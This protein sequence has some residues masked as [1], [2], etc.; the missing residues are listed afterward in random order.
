[1]NRNYVPSLDIQHKPTMYS[2]VS[3]HSSP[4]SSLFYKPIRANPSNVN[5]IPSLFHEDNQTKKM[6]EQFQNHTKQQSRTILYTS[7]SGNL[8]YR[9]CPQC[10]Q[11]GQIIDNQSWLTCPAHHSFFA[12]PWCGDTRISNIKENVRYCGQNHPYSF[13]KIHTRQPVPG[14]INPIQMVCSCSLN[15]KTP[16]NMLLDPTA[17]RSTD[18]SSPFL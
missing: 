3:E 4:S 10:G 13:C 16:K 6:Q 14:I 1:M 12:C 15:M 5:A 7:H 2:T 9:Q 18:W 17:Q 8:P 11:S